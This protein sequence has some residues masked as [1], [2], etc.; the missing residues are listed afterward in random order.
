MRGS[1]S[2]IEIKNKNSTVINF[3]FGEE[4]KSLILNSEKIICRSGYSTLMDLHVLN[5][6]N[7][8]LI[9]TPGQT[10]QEYLAGYWEKKFGAKI[11]CQKNIPKYNFDFK[12]SK[13]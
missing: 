6:K 5:A 4:L 9:P 12:S 7:L 2:E 1:D 8:I 13:I 3:A 11:V 10:E